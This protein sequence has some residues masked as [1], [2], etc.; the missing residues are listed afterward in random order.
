MGLVVIHPF[1]VKLSTL[2]RTW[3]VH[4]ARR[5]MVDV[6]GR[7]SICPKE[8][9]VADSASPSSPGTPLIGNLKS[10]SVF[11]CSWVGLNSI[12]Y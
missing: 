5:S 7:E 6:S 11:A 3:S 4:V 9:H 8:K 2:L 1:F 10:P 12:S